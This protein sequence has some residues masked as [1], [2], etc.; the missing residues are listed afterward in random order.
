MLTIKNI[1]KNKS[2]VCVTR[3]SVVVANIR[4]FGKF[5]T[6]KTMK[7][8]ETLKEVCS[9]IEMDVEYYTDNPIWI[10]DNVAIC[11]IILTTDTYTYN[12]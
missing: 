2:K 5:L 8:I 7:N 3:K 4:N 10:N 1:R 9:E 6:E 11:K 12:G